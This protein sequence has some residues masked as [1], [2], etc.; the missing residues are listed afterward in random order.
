MPEEEKFVWLSKDVILTFHEQALMKYGGLHGVRD[1]GL[2]ESALARPQNLAAYENKD[3]FEC[4][5]AYAYGI[6]K[7]HPFVDANKRTALF[8]CYAFLKRNGQYLKAPPDE[9]VVMM[10]ALASGK[11]SEADFAAWLRKH[12]TKQK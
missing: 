9:C 12:S 10:V 1:E 8:S 3:V 11:A 5:A 2:L 4:A 7:N 6:A